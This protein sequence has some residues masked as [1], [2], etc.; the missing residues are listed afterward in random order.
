MDDSQLKSYVKP[1]KVIASLNLNVYSKWYVCTKW[2]KSHVL[3]TRKFHF[4]STRIHL[5]LGTLIHLMVLSFT[6]N[7]FIAQKDNWTNFDDFHKIYSEHLIL[8]LRT[9]MQI[10]IRFYWWIN[11]CSS[12]FVLFVSQCWLLRKIHVNYYG[13]YLYKDAVSCARLSIV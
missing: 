2:L 5:N 11:G 3:F 8:R 9:D 4:I 12:Y 1:A 10:K 13:Y 6:L 7:L